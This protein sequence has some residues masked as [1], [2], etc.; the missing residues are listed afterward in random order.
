MDRR[1]EKGGR[2]VGGRKSQSVL[3]KCCIEDDI[4][5]Q[6]VSSSGWSPSHSDHAWTICTTGLS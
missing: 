4:P 6:C 1:E 2:G 3:I 5:P